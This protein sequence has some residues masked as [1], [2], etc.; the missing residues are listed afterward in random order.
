M[1]VRFTRALANIYKISKGCLTCSLAHLRTT[2]LFV[3]PKMTRDE[4]RTSFMRPYNGHRL[5][6]RRTSNGRAVGYLWWDYPC[7]V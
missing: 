3:V 7:S 4:S 1:L 6:T 5:V 2:L